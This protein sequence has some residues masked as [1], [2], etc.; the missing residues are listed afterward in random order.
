MSSKIDVRRIL[1]DHIQTLRNEKTNKRSLWD[2]TLFFLIPACLGAFSI[3]KGFSFSDDAVGV[4]I[5]A[6]SIFAGLLINVLVLIYSIFQNITEDG[7]GQNEQGLSTRG[8]EKR[9]LRE[10]FANIS[11]AILV[12]VSTVILVSLAQAFDIKQPVVF[13]GIVVAF[14]INFILTLLMALKRIHALLSHK[15]A[16]P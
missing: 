9:F 1:S 6:L 7:S 4:L 8:E 15:L 3:H 12:A 13:S 5:T 11:F 2:L 10:I 16:S 14:S